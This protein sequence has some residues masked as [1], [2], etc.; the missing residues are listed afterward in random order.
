M[1][2]RIT[3]RL[4]GEGPR[5]LGHIRQCSGDTPGSKLRSDPSGA[6]ENTGSVALAACKATVLLLGPPAPPSL[7]DP[8]KF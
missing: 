1:V 5:Q 2:L 6:W 4:G 3:I 7:Y 8:T